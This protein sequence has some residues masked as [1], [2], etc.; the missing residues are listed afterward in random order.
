MDSQSESYADYEFQHI[1]L[2][3]GLPPGGETDDGVERVFTFEPVDNSGIDNDELAEIVMIHRHVRVED[4]K[5]TSINISDDPSRI[6]AEYGLGINTETPNEFAQNFANNLTTEEIDESPSNVSRIAVTDSTDQLD[7]WGSTT[8]ATFSDEANGNGGPAGSL[9]EDTFTFNFRDHFGTGPFLDRTDELGIF[10]ELAKR[11]NDG[12]VV[13]D[14]QLK[15]A[16][17]VHDVEGGRAAF[18]PPRMGDD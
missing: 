3:T 6:S 13:L 11:G 16:Y 7:F 17:E 18:A 9:A 4:N 15:I 5:A 14:T 2:Q 10:H 8:Q 12:D 1:S